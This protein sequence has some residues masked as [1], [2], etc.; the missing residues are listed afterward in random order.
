MVPIRGHRRVGSVPSVLAD[1][2]ATPPAH[3][4]AVRAA[5]VR[6][7]EAQRL[8]FRWVVCFPDGHRYQGLRV[9]RCRV[10]FGDPHVV[11]YCA[12]LRRG[13]LLTDHERPRIRCGA[14]PD[15]LA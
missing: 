6:R 2:P 11:Q 1:A 12:V 4:Q 3:V 9:V 8:T 15:P 14:R 7:L 13:Q 10:H 5:L